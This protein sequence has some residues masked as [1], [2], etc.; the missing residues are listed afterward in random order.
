[1]GIKLSKERS[2]CRIG[3]AL[4]AGAA[5]DADITMTGI[6]TTD[7]LITFIEFATST[8]IPTDRLAEASITEDDVV[9]CTDT[10]AS[11][12]VFVQWVSSVN[13]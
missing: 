13:D 12:L 9:Q 6:R 1:M 11:D 3:S 7:E 2:N 10:T 8:A 4:V 5:A